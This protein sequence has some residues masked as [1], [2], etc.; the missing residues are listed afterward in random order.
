VRRTPGSMT[1]EGLFALIDLVR[2]ARVES[3]R[4]PA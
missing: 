4:L 1:A 2:G 3:A